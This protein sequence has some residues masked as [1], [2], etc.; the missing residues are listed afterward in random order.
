MTT[1]N[2]PAV[3]HVYEAKFG[4]LA[5]HLDFKADGKTMEFSSVGTAAPVAEPVVAVTYTATEVAPQVFMVTWD[6]PDG[7]TVTHVEDFGQ[8]IVYT[9]ITLPD[10][11]FLNYKGSFKLLKQNGKLEDIFVLFFAFGCY[12]QNDFFDFLSLNL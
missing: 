4:D 5:Y 2:Y 9:N 7:S 8:E 6:E 10:H 12:F 3:G 1:T 11:Q